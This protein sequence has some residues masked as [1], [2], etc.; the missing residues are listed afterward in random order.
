MANS[1]QCSFAR[2][3]KKYL[4]TPAQQAVILR[5]ALRRMK[6]DVYGRYTICNI[7]YDTPDWRLIRTCLEKPV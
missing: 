4:I 7:Y 1:I 3:E 6:E 2:Y 5:E